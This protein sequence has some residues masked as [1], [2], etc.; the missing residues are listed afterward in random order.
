MAQ[1]NGKQHAPNDAQADRTAE[2]V[3]AY[4][5]QIGRRPTTI[6]RTLRDRAAHLTAI[7]EFAAHDPHVS[8]DDVVRLDHSAALARREFTAAITTRTTDEMP[9]LDE[10]LAG[11]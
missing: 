7:A 3:R 2:L 4:Q 8:F 10:L 1:I 11:E 5:R 9:S 6:Q